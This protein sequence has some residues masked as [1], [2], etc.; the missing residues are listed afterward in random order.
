MK[1]VLT[2]KKNKFIK[3]LLD[4]ISILK[5]HNK[6]KIS[7]FLRIEEVRRIVNYTSMKAVALRIDWFEIA[8]LFQCRQ[9]K[10]NYYFDVLVLIKNLMV[11]L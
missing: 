5:E 2:N 10:S 1:V 7:Q 8:K 9:E 3:K 4:E 11:M 6:R